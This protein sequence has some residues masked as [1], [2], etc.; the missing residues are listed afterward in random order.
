MTAVVAVL[1]I[2]R[3]AARAMLPAGLDLSVQEFMP[4]D[5]HPLVLILGEQSDVRPALLPLGARYREFILAVPFVEGRGRGA[6]GPFCY[7][8]CLFLDRRVPTLAGRLLYG[9]EKR[10][11][12]IR[13]TEHSYRIADH[14]LGELLQADFRPAGAAVKASPSGISLLFDLP[15]IARAAGGWR[16]SLADIGLDRALIQPVEL[17]LEIH[18]PFVPGLP[19]GAVAISGLRDDAS[20]AFRIRTSWRLAGPWAR[21]SPP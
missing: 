15:V 3:A 12:E 14:R 9:Y 19:V 4:G 10:L 21:S 11:A 1:P 5:R 7:A 20:R 13:M 18:R 17:R 16:Y 6:K 2:A 8:P